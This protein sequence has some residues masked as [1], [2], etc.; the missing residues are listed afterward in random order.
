MGLFHQRWTTHARQCAELLYT[1]NVF[2]L[3][4]IDV[5]PMHVEVCWWLYIRG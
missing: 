1:Y 3:L 2:Y 5:A 4:Q